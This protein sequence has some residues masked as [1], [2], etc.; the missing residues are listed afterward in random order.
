MQH[1][2]ERHYRRRAA[3]RTGVT[4]Q[5]WL[6][7]QLVHGVYCFDPKIA[8]CGVLPVPGKTAAEVRAGLL[9][10]YHVWYRNQAGG[11]ALL[12]NP[13]T[14][15]PFLVRFDP[16]APLPAVAPGPP[17]PPGPVPAPG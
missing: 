3:G 7:D 5:R 2:P 8:E 15:R 6:H 12:T 10:A 14:G 11:I 9:P 4:A 1:P 17:P 13:K 16:D